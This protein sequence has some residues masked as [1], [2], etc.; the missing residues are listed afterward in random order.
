L[1][2][3]ENYELN[4][5]EY[6]DC[7]LKIYTITD[8]SFFDNH[9]DSVNFIILSGGIVTEYGVSLVNPGDIINNSIAKK[10]I[11]VFKNVIP[12]TKVLVIEKNIV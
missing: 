1:S 7:L 6:A 4:F 5:L 9:D 3:N 2:I 10:I 8:A 11:S 12:N